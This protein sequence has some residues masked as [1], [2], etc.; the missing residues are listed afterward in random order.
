MSEQ[1]NEKDQHDP[2]QPQVTGGGGHEPQPQEQQSSD[3]PEPGAGR[4]VDLK[5][6]DLPET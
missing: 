5:S 2:G 4:G 6:S 1:T 3:A